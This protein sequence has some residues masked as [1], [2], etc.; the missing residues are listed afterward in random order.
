M[1]RGAAGAV[2]DDARDGNIIRHELHHVRRQFC[3]RNRR[4]ILKIFRRSTQRPI[5]RHLRVAAL[6]QALQ[7]SW[8]L[9]DLLMRRLHNLQRLHMCFKGGKLRQISLGQA[10]PTLVAINGCRRMFV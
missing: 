6:N 1:P 5:K 7:P 4:N 3:A 8:R 2:M 9:R 10:M